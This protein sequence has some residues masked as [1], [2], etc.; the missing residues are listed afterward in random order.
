MPKSGI[1]NVKIRDSPIDI[2][3]YFVIV[4]FKINLKMGGL[5]HEKEEV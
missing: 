1:S 2:I 4:I 5:K 3:L